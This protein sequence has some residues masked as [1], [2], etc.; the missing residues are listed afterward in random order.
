MALAIVAAACG[1][2]NDVASDPVSPTETPAQTSSSLVTNDTPVPGSTDGTF[3]VGEGSEATFT[4]EKLS[5]LPLPNDAVLRTGEITGEVD[6]SDSTASL[7]ID[8]HSL[9]SDEANRDKYVRDRL[10]PRQPEATINITKFPDIPETFAAGESFTATVTGIV[11][12]NGADTEIEFEIEARLDP[13]RLLVL[14]KGDFTWADFGMTAPSS[15]FFV[16]KD[17]VHFEVLV[18]AVPS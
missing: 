8:L 6:L 15:R 18:S 9:D 7:V 1:S 17:D 16:V 2:G 11:N 13:D 14:V 10:F 4:V 12:V 5:R 3:T